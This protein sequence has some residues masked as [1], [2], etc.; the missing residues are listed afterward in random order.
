MIAMRRILREP[1]LHFLVLGAA[2]FAAFQLAGDRGEATPGKIVV[3][4]GKIDH[5]VTGFTRTW[6]RPPTARE[7]DVLVEDYLREEVFYREALLL[8]L[9]KDDTIVRRRMRQ[10]LEFLAGDATSMVAPTDTEL[11]AWL[12]RNPDKFRVEPTRAF[13]QIYFAGGDKPPVAAARALEQLGRAAGDSRAAPLGDATMLPREMPP[14][15][16]DEIGRVFGNRF[17]GEVARLEPGRWSGPVQSGYGWHLVR[18]SESTEGGTRSL[19]EV[20]EAVKREWQAARSREVVDAA[21]AALRGKYIISIE[22]A[23]TP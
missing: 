6:R 15:A 1:L 4:A 5:L 3:T 21:Y 9:D 10:K 18:V 23:T 16:V 11:Q 8:G 13:S 2:L 17:A 14:S 7:L 12:E 22:G 19:S 20:R